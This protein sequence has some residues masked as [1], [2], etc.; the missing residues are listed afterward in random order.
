MQQHIKSMSVASAAPFSHQAA[1]SY[2]GVK[3]NLGSDAFMMQHTKQTSPG[4]N[5]S[6]RFA[7]QG[8]KT[9]VGAD[10]FVNSELKRAR[11]NLTPSKKR[12]LKPHIGADSL[13]NDFAKKQQAQTSF[14]NQFNPLGGHS[15][16]LPPRPRIGAD[17]MMSDFAKKQQASQR[18]TFQYNMMGGERPKPHITGDAFVSAQLRVAKAQTPATTRQYQGIK[19]SIGAD[20]FHMAF[21]NSIKSWTKT[22]ETGKEVRV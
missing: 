21:L 5:A 4:G 3:P 9:H 15:G 11:E 1:H 13:F 19:P 8:V 20:S 17:S 10:T 12:E 14:S 7:Y 2:Q 16:G 22:K 18:N 6:T